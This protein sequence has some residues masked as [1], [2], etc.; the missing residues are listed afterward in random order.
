MPVGPTRTKAQKQRVVH[1]EMKKFSE[2]KLHSGSKKGPVVTNPKQAIA[3][4]MLESKQ[5]KSKRAVKEKNYDRSAHHPG[6]PG[7]NREGKP[8][9]AEYNGGAH[10]KQPKG[11]SMGIHDGPQGHAGQ[12]Y[13]EEQKEHWGNKMGEGHERHGNK[14]VANIPANTEGSE[15]VGDCG[16]GHA[17]QPHGKSIDGGSTDVAAH[18]KGYGMGSPHTFRQPVMKESHGFSGTVKQG[19]FRV[20]GHSGAHRVGKR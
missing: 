4:S 2:G 18:H 1:T 12:T 20:S 6:N 9:Y 17:K 3:I 7:F 5:S 13:H 16:M 10:A 8:P 11:K 19:F 14:P 15:L